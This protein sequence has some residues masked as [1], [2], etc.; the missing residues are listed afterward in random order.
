MKNLKIILGTTTFAAMSFLTS[1]AFCLELKKMSL[2]DKVSSS[3]LVFIGLVTKT[4]RNSQDFGY[5][6][7]ITQPIEV[8][9]GNPSEDIKIAY[10]GTIPEAQ[11][12]CCEVGKSYLFFV[13]K[14][15]KGDYYPVNGRYGVYPLNIE[16]P[17][18]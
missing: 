8:L 16:N 5:D 13:S 2:E 3:D 18:K 12:N 6:L 4:Q 9:K 10:N 17:R 11:P 14:N 15:P 1:S 7:A